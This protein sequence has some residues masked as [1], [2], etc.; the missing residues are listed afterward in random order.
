M[1]TITWPIAVYRNLSKVWSLV[2]FFAAPSKFLIFVSF[3]NYNLKLTL[4]ILICQGFNVLHQYVLHRCSTSMCYDK[5]ATSMSH[6][7]VLWRCASSMCYVDVLHRCAISMSYFN[8]LRQWAKSMCYIN[9]LRQCATSMFYSNVLQQCATSMCY[10]DVLLRCAMSMSYVNV[11]CQWAT[12]M[13]Y[14]YVLCHVLGQWATSM[15]YIN[16]LW[17]C[18]TNYKLNYSHSC[19]TRWWTPPGLAW[20]PAL[21]DHN[22]G[23]KHQL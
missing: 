3:L 19:H 15:C 12:T 18:A 4:H 14:I 5:F 20:S 8:V 10:D 9:V 21:T 16:V 22:S 13:C 2:S 1:W 11:L 23:T 7:N 17:Q 6:N